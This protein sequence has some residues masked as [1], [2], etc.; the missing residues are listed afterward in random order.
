MKLNDENTTEAVKHAVEIATV[1]I[2]GSYLSAA[3]CTRA[4]GRRR[5]EESS[6]RCKN[7]VLIPGNL[8]K[9]LKSVSIL[10]GKSFFSD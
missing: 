5:Y 2:A 6:H 7:G 9:L 3:A 10:R 1:H 4:G 8:L